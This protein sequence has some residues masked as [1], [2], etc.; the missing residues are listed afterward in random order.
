MISQYVI[1]FKK[2]DEDQWTIG[3]IA[4]PSKAACRVALHHWSPDYDF[5]A[6]QWQFT[7]ERLDVLLKREAPYPVDYTNLRYHIEEVST[8]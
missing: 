2:R 5:D 1:L 6:R 7:F 3:K 8:G 4:Y